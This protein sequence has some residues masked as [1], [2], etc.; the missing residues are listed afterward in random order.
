MA[1]QDLVASA[2][3]KRVAVGMVTITMCL[4]GCYWFS[5]GEN[6]KRRSQSKYNRN[7]NLA[8]DKHTAARVYKQCYRAH[9]MQHHLP[10][11]YTVSF[12]ISSSP[13]FSGGRSGSC[14]K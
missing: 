1:E 14:T 4:S 8:A 6:I 10:A 12:P 11:A 5:K 9:P 13:T 3:D 7:L 2:G